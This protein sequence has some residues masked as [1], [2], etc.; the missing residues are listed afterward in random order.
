MLCPR[1]LMLAR[2]IQAEEGDVYAQINLGCSNDV[3]ED[4]KQ[5]FV[6]AVNWYRMAAE[7][8]DDQGQFNL[9]V[10]YDRG[11]GV[12][13]DLSEAVRLYRLAATKGHENAQYSLGNIYDK[14]LGVAQDCR[15]SQMV[16]PFRDK[17]GHAHT[18][19]HYMYT[20]VSVRIAYARS[21]SQKP[22][23]PVYWDAKRVMAEASGELYIRPPRAVI[24]HT[25]ALRRSNGE[26]RVI[27]ES[28]LACLSFF[29]CTLLPQLLRPL[30][31]LRCP[32]LLLLL[33]LPRR[34]AKSLLE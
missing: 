7:Q 20:Y 29:I 14:G 16:K 19:T 21:K 24:G 17:T 2:L 10:K 9:G 30:L 6:K 22:G 18:L 1:K 25:P 34:P 26:P 33:P 5:D 4:A 8:G 28:V 12:K 15:G 31:G 27:A 3:G 23:A 13:G 32:L 11:Q